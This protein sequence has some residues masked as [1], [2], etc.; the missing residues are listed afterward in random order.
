MTTMSS[1]P[2]EHREYAALLSHP[3]LRS[4]LKKKLVGKNLKAV[5]KQ[6]LVAQAI[7]ALWRR[8]DDRDPPRTLERLLGLAATILHGKL[9]DHYRHND[10]VAELMV[11]A[12]R[13][14]RIRKGDPRPVNP[15][16]Q[17][18]YVEEILPLRSM[19]PL[20]ALEAKEKLEFFE[21]EGAKLGV[22]EDDV[23]VMVAYEC[24]EAG[25]EELAAERG[26][27][28]GALRTRLHRLHGKLSDAWKHHVNRGTIILTVL[29]LAMLL[30]YA[31]ALIGPARNSPP[32][33]PAPPIPTVLQPAPIAP[34]PPARTT[35]PAPRPPGVNPDG[36]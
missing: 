6:D 36:K 35:A 14:A 15:R 31:L 9:V 13:P 18:N 3:R 33:P 29:V 8:R 21:K 17:P 7:D 4:F 32:P 26:K 12:P 20:D 23:E 25:L 5:D 2:T 30:L 24:G 11:D 10:V 1:N 22:T 16:A 34:S 27:T 19:T 28:G